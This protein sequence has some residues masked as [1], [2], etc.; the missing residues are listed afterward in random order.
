MRDE[1]AAIFHSIFLLLIDKE[2]VLPDEVE[3]SL[4]FNHLEVT[5]LFLLS[6]L[7]PVDLLLLA[8]FIQGVY[9]LGENSYPI[10]LRR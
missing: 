2:V 8:P 3:D 4:T 9:L 7:E 10:K 5:V 1:I 6:H